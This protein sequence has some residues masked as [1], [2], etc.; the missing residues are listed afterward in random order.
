VTAVVPPGLPRLQAGAHL[1]PED[2]ACLM[3]YVSVLAGA[4]FSDRPRCTDPTLAAFARLVNDSCSDAGRAQLVLFAPVLAETPRSDAARTAALVQVLV[5]AACTAVG[6][7][8]TLQRQLRRAERRQ[9]TVSGTGWRSAVARRLNGL[10][11]RGPARHSLE[12][13][14]RALR[15]LT[16]AQRDAVL[17]AMLAEALVAAGPADRRTT[18]AQVPPPVVV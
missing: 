3:E 9:E 10:Y 15:G 5:R 14:V 13:T 4:R 8:P 2:G 6:A 1:L 11:G 12:V 18:D 7:T 17:V 16:E